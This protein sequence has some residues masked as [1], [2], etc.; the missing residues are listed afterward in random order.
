[1]LYIFDIN[2]A[3]L[4]LCERKN[5]AQRRKDAKF[6]GWNHHFLTFLAARLTAVIVMICFC[7]FHA[8]GQEPVDSTAVS[9]HST[10]APVDSSGITPPDTVVFKSDLPDI[11]DPDIILISDEDALAKAFPLDSLNVDAYAQHSPA[12]AAIMSAVLPGLGQIYNRK[13]W[14]VPIVYIAIGISVERF[15][16]FQNKYNQYV[17]AYIDINDK[18]PYTNYHKTLGG[19]TTYSEEQQRQIIT[20]GKEKF[21]TWRDYAI[22]GMIASYA[23]VNIIWANVDAHL[24]DFNL[25]DNLSFNIRPCFLENGFNSQKFGLTLQFTF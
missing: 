6:R 21:R 11:A 2:F 1:V 24:I 10:A 19:L 17:R 8:A 22:I 15:I 16:T 7:S 3:P 20:R 13:Y 25:D 18:D 12:K 9:T 23:V 4:R 14:E 5:I